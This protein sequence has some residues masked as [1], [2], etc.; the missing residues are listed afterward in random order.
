MLMSM[1]TLYSAFVSIILLFVDILAPVLSLFCFTDHQ[2]KCL[3]KV[4]R[5]FLGQIRR[6]NI[7]HKIRNLEIKLLFLVFLLLEAPCL[8]VTHLSR[9]RR[10]PMRAW[11]TRPE[12]REGAK[13]E[14]KRP[15]EPPT[16]S[17]ARKN[18]IPKWYQGWSGFFR[19]QKYTWRSTF[20]WRATLSYLISWEG[21]VW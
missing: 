12:R 18:E 17:Q 16:G 9:F 3:R 5:S 1:C 20:F 10:W 4:Q 11:V 2:R 14:V 7:Q 15:E 13:D 6:K 19:N 8:L 21:Y